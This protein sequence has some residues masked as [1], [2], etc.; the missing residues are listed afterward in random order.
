ML[1][2]W[3]KYDPELQLHQEQT[4]RWQFKFLYT[5]NEIVISTVN[6]NDY[7]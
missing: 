1:I 5:H 7:I 2:S 6:V 3:L 4:Q